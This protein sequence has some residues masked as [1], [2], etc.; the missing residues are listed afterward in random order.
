MAEITTGSSFE[1][2]VSREQIIN[3]QEI[4]NISA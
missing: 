1:P 3:G 4:V 2:N